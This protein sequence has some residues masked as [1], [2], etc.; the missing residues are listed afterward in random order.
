MRRLI[1]LFALLLNLAPALADEVLKPG[2]AL[3]FKDYNGANFKVS[4]EGSS[5]K[6]YCFCTEWSGTSFMLYRYRLSGAT[7]QL[8]VTSKAECEL[9][10]N[11]NPLCEILN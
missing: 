5:V 8:S 2:Q 9:R 1:L 4:C 3:I 7:D 11:A 10:K 6:N